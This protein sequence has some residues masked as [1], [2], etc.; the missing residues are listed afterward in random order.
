M[1]R[2]ESDGWRDLPSYYDRSMSRHAVQ[3]RLEWYGLYD[4][5][6]SNVEDYD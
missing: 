1:S 3:D 4:D 2:D 5:N 6:E